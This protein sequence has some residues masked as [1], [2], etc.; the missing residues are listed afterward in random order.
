MNLNKK[1]INKN[2]LSHKDILSDVFKKFEKIKKKIIFIEK[3]NKLIGTITDGDIRKIHF[4]NNKKTISV[5]DVMN[6]KPKFILAVMLDEPKTNRE[7][8]TGI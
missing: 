1:D 2:C 5:L 4:S 7:Y 3:S 6:S 8:I